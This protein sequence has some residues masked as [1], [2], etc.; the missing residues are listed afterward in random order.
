MNGEGAITVIS[1]V[2]P[3][4][5]SHVPM[6]DTTVAAQMSRNV[7]TAS[8]LQAEDAIVPRS[9]VGPGLLTEDPLIN[10]RIPRRRA[11]GVTIPI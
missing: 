7:G 10:L 8:G 6:F 9:L 2:V 4:A 3:T 1:Q 5:L 11:D